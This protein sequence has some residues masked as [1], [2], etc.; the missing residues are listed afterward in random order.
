VGKIIY[1]GDSPFRVMPAQAPTARVLDTAV[2]MT[3]YASVD[4]KG[5][6]DTQ[7]QIPMTAEYARELAAQLTASAI[8]ADM[9]ARR[10]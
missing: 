10:R 7:I 1:Q 9:R 4:R 8:A 3:V 5:P 2:E 6:D